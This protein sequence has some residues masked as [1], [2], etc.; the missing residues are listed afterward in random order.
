MS[1]HICFRLLFSCMIIQ[2]N[3][4]LVCAGSDQP[5]ITM[6][7]RLLLSVYL[8]SSDQCTDAS[9]ADGL[10]SPIWEQKVS[11]LRGRGLVPLL[12]FF[13]FCPPLPLSLS[14]STDQHY[15]I[16]A[17]L[18]C[19]QGHRSGMVL[20]GWL[21]W[22]GAP[23]ISGSSRLC[24]CMQQFAGT[25][26]DM[27]APGSWVIIHSGDQRVPRYGT[28]CALLLICHWS[29]WDIRFC[30]CDLRSGVP[31]DDLSKRLIVYGVYV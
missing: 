8:L 17:P 18:A 25:A 27:V 6:S 31:F 14:L 9:I 19:L 29:T 15:V 1:H 24:I 20:P 5:R 3:T 21:C 16:L 28:M 10:L 7:G 30:F 22:P 4:S 13:L 11:S 12:A 26:S 2:K 23:C